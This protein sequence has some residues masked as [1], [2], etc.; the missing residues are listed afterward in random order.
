MTSLY[1]SVSVTF[2]HGLEGSDQRRV[3][4]AVIT[5]YGVSEFAIL[6][7]LQRQYPAYTN[8]SILE[9]EER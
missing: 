8:I 2:E 7:E 9:V 4:R 1:R 3:N 6:A 5:V